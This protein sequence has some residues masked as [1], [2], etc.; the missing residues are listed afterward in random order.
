[1]EA[2]KEQMDDHERR[3]CDLEGRQR[4][5]HDEATKH[6]VELEFQAQQSKAILERL[7][8]QDTKMDEFKSAIFAKLNTTLWGI[9]AAVIAALLSGLV[10]V[11]FLI[12]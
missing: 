7:D 6:D 12:K 1:M 9:A 11:A 8:Q 10:W 4:E 5:D 3:L 2:L